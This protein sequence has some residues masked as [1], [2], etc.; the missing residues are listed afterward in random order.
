M[1]LAMQWSVL[2]SSPAGRAEWMEWL[3]G[4]ECEREKISN[5]IWKEIRV[6]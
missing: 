3:D 5:I 2:K 6:M 1:K 4:V